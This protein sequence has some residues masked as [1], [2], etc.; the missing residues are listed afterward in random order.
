MKIYTGTGDQGKTS[1]FN[2]ERVT[3][4]HHRIEVYGE[5]DELNS[6]LGAIIAHLPPVLPATSR[7]LQSIQ[8]IM[9]Q[10]GALLATP[11]DSKVFQSLKPLHS[12]QIQ[13]LESWIDA[14]ESE[15]PPLEVFIL[16]GGTPAAACTHIA[17]TVCRRVERHLIRYFQAPSEPETSSDHLQPLMIY[18]NRL[19]DYLFQLARFLNKN[20][21]IPDQTGIN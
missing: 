8:I 18:L 10:M 5:I 4:S 12:T 6:H 16:P 20:A 3:K 17:R 9:Q 7:Q 2:G 1:L 14:L 21:G 13:N 19:S 11:S 15:L